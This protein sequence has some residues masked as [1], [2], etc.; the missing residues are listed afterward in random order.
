MILNRVTKAKLIVDM[1][2]FPLED[3]DFFKNFTCESSEN[4]GVATTLHIIS[5]PYFFFL[6]TKITDLCNPT[7]VIIE[8]RTRDPN[9]NLIVQLYEK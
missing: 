9:S 5:N 7:Q 2:C 8:G 1:P 3:H 4:N 6:S